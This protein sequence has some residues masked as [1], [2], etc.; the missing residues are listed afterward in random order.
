VDILRTVTLPHLQLFI[1]TELSSLSSA[2]ELRILKR[3][4]PPLG[5]GE[6]FFCCPL[7]PS[8]GTTAS[9]GSSSG[10]MLRTLNFTQAGRVKKIRGIASSVRVSPQMANRMIDSARGVLNRYI[11]DLYLFADVYKGE[12]SGK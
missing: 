4:C 3:G 8:T 2:L 11:P 10:G 6:V 5:G 12:D 9:G 1:P 7:L